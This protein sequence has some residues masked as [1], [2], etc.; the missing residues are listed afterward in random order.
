MQRNNLTVKVK[1]PRQ[2]LAYLV[3][4]KLLYIRP[5]LAIILRKTAHQHIDWRCWA[6]RQKSI[7]PGF[8][9]TM[10]FSLSSVASHEAP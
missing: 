1:L 5:E 3:L 6:L 7:E 2:Q 10:F 8:D 4:S 9:R